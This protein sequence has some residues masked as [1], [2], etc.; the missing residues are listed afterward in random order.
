MTLSNGDLG[1]STTQLM[2]GES[3]LDCTTA[4]DVLNGEEQDGIAARTLLD[5]KSNGGLTYNDFLIL[6]GYIGTMPAWHTSLPIRL[7]ITGRLCCV[8]CSS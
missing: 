5:S 2:P 8:R 7:T 6:P 1:T 4:L 3:A